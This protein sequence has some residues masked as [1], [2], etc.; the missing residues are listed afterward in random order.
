MQ[1]LLLLQTGMLRMS[2][3]VR[4]MLAVLSG[5][6]ALLL[7]L[8]RLL[9]APRGAGWLWLWEVFIS[10]LC[11]PLSFW[12]GVFFFLSVFF[13]PCPLDFLLSWDFVPH[14]TE[15]CCLV[16]VA[17]SLSHTHTHTHLNN[18]A[19]SIPDCVTELLRAWIK[20]KKKKKKSCRD[21]VNRSDWPWRQEL[22]LV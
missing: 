20:Q 5:L 9:A 15:I 10:A 2:R 21:V 16:C 7:R 8:C 18:H 17:L 14:V 6:M 13:P 4:E 22:M 3:A 12:W 11:W 19:R 1:E